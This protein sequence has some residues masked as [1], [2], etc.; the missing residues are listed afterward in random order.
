MKK[1]RIL[2]VDDEEDICKMFTKWLSLDGHNA[3]SV[4]KGQEAIELVKKDGFNFVFLDKPR[5]KKFYDL[6]LEYVLNLKKLIMEQNLDGESV[7]V[8]FD[9]LLPV[10]NHFYR[11]RISLT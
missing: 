5:F 2:V 10:Y 9:S 8:Y 4:L 7:F 3:K 11:P 6:R 1:L